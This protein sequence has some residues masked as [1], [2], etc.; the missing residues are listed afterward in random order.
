[1][2]YVTTKL[3]GGNFLGRLLLVRDNVERWRDERRFDV[4]FELFGQSHRR[5]GRGYA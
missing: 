1:M 4:G 3:S 5:F 2:E